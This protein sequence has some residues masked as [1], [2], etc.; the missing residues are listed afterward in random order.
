MRQHVNVVAVFLILAGVGSGQLLG[1][2]VYW[3]DKN[4]STIWRGDM[5]GSGPREMLLDWSDGLVEPRGL[6]L[7]VGAGKMYW[8]DAGTGRIS[9]ADLDGGDIETLVTGLPFVGDLELDVAGGKMYWAET[10]G[11]SIGRADLDGSNVVRLFTG[12]TAPYYLALDIPAGMMYWGEESN[13]RIFSGRMDGTGTVDEFQTG[14]N[15]VRDI[16]VDPANDMIYWNERDLHEVKRSEVGSGVLETLFTVPDGGKPH[17][18]ALDVPER[19]IYWTT[20]GTDSIMRGP[21]DGS[22]PYELLYTSPGAPWDI[23]LAVVPEP[24]T[25]ALTIAGLAGVTRTST[26][27]RRR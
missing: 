18:M 14:M 23:E 13:T 7:D 16:G 4:D 27:R 12:E 25:L 3:T 10:A 15:R 8:A 17:G 5:D 22:G 19:M 21:M 20:T 24:S 26:R 6:G 2:R 9:R 1:G 11:L